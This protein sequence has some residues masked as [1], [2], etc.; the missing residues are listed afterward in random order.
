MDLEIS[1]RLETVVG[2]PVLEDV[3]GTCTHWDSW[4]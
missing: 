4:W 1:Y 3:C 2:Y